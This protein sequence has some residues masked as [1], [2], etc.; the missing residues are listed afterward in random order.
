MNK[1]ELRDEL[2]N[3]TGLSRKDAE[4]AVNALFATDRGGIIA[5]ELRKGGK[6]RIT[7]FGTFEARDRKARTG[8]N[9]RTG[10]PVEISAARYPAFKAGRGFKERVDQR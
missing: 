1:T 2:A 3:R 7:G 10:D 6:V 4:G 9:P 8:R 5:D